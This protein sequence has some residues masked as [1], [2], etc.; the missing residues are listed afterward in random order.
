MPTRCRARARDWKRAI[1]NC[2]P[3]AS[4]PVALQ[5][6]GR[7]LAVDL[8]LVQRLPRGGA[9][10]LRVQRRA[11]GLGLQ[12]GEGGFFLREP[13]A[14]FRAVDRGEDVAL[15]DRVARDHGQV[16]GAARDGVQGRAVGRDH[17]SLGGDVAH[18]VAARHG[19]DPHAVG[20]ERTAAGRPPRHEPGSGE[21]EGDA[22]RAAQQPALSLLL[23]D[24]VG[25]GT[26]LGGGVADVHAVW[27]CPDGRVSPSSPPLHAGTVPTANPL[28]RKQRAA[29]HGCPRTP[30]CP[31]GH[32]HRG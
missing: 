2:S 15:L 5:V 29:G 6:A 26:V 12:A 22:Q 27:S 32:G 28:I 13:A 9:C 20:I 1:A 24:A 10:D 3:T 31:P 30:M 17:P 4:A 14:Q 8:G 23:R 25:E 16:H 18:Q 19:G 11:A 21:Q 7:C